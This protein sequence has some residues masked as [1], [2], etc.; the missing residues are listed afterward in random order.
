M[1]VKEKACGTLE[2]VGS[3]SLQL[4]LER[5]LLSTQGPEENQDCKAIP[6]TL[7]SSHDA[8]TH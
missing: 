4:L 5:R 1:E 2:A 7:R 8:D 3:K 6:L